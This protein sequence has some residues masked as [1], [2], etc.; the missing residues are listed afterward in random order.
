MFQCPWRPIDSD[1]DTERFYFEPLL[2]TISDNQFLLTLLPEIKAIKFYV[3][4]IFT[5]YR[6]SKI[7]YLLYDQ[8][9]FRNYLKND[10]ILFE[11]L[12]LFKFGSHVWDMWDNRDNFHFYHA[13]LTV[14]A[15]FVSFLS[16]SCLNYF[17]YLTFFRIKT[18]IFYLMR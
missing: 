7:W 6:T 4:I 12:V 10:L 2:W 3:I 18:M 8:I 15:F 5:F 11:H 14:G 13:F 17:T 16:Q 1:S 9:N